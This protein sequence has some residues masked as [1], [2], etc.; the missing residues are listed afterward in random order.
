MRH[1][2]CC[3]LNG[4]ISVSDAEKA[5]QVMIEVIRHI[6]KW[7]SNLSKQQ[8]QEL[9]CRQAAFHAAANKVLVSCKNSETKGVVDLVIQAV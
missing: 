6:P 2:R 5:F 4:R 1:M 9:S 3:F 8:H 7:F